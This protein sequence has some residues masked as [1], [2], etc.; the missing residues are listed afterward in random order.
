MA[1]RKQ[2]QVLACALLLQ[3]YHHH[4]LDNADGLIASYQLLELWPFPPLM[5]SPPLTK[6][7]YMAPI[8]RICCVLVTECTLCSSASELRL[9]VEDFVACS[10]IPGSVGGSVAEVNCPLLLLSVEPPRLRELNKEETLLA[11]GEK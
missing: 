7:G 9:V 4:P 2:W 5:D 8:A 3:N 10:W 11:K 1:S 6:L